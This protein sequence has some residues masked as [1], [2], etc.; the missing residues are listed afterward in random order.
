MKK[1]ESPKTD[2]VMLQTES[3]LLENSYIP[4]GGEGTPAGS[5]KHTGGIWGEGETESSSLW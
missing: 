1:Y 4:P 2:V 3:P 5:R